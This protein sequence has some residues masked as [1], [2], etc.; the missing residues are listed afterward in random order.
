M[1]KNKLK[2]I[3]LIFA[4]NKVKKDKLVREFISEFK[5]KFKYVEKKWLWESVLYLI[6]LIN[7]TEFKMQK[8]VS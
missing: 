8:R 1:E 5:N 7:S 6:N 4:I 3:G 2:N